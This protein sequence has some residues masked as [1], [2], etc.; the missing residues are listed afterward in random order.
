MSHPVGHQSDGKTSSDAFDCRSVKPLLYAGG[1]SLSVIAA[2]AY[3]QNRLFAVFAAAAFASA[4]IA[5]GVDIKKTA[6]RDSNAHFGMLR[7]SVC[8]SVLTCAWSAAALFLAYPIAGLHWLHG[9]EYGLL[10]VLITFAFGLYW[11]RLANCHDKEAQLVAITRAKSL[12]TVQA[13]AIASTIVW[14]VATGKLRTIKGDWLANDVFLA[15]G[16]A[17]LALSVLLVTALRQ[18]EA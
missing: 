2:A 8:L 7:N 1:L 12:A 4:V 17:M 9:W 16:C 5:A 6:G 11:Q 3:T 10:F 14:I 15:S 18:T 13:I